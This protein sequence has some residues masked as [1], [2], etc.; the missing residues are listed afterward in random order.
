MEW[1]VH[2]FPAP[3]RCISGP[4]ARGCSSSDGRRILL[5][6]PCPLSRCSSSFHAPRGCSVLH[7]QLLL[8]VLDTVEQP[9]FLWDRGMW[10]WS[11]D[12]ALPQPPKPRVPQESPVCVPHPVA[13]FPQCVPAD[14]IWHWSSLTISGDLL[15]KTATGLKGEEEGTWLLREKL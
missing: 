11:L 3:S 1:S 7:Q 9:Q 12:W 13:A 6:I 4:A 2:G 10:G 5:L 8:Q 14:S 15:E